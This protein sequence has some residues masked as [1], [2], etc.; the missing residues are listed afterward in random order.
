M[1]PASA[2]VSI[3]L[4][5]AYLMNGLPIRST[6]KDYQS[7]DLDS[8]GNWNS[9]DDDGTVTDRAHNEAN[10]LTTMSQRKEP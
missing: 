10:E 4:P 3:H 1:L 9:F 8:L 7:W 5:F 2:L 6:G